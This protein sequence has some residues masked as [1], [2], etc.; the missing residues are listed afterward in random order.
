MNKRDL[1]DEFYRILK[2]AEN[3]PLEA[4]NLIYEEFE[5]KEFNY[6][7][8]LLD[9]WNEWQKLMK[10]GGRKYYNYYRVLEKSV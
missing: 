6:M 10:L 4:Y 9:R 2:R 8:R 3:C 5:D 7:C 1:A